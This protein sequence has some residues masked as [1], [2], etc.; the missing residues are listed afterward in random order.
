MRHSFLLLIYFFIFSINAQDSI[1]IYFDINSCVLDKNA[2]SSLKNIE[3]Y[4]G[5]IIGVYGFTDTIGSIDF[6][7]KLALKRINSICNY[8]KMSNPISEKEASIGEL[9]QFAP[10]DKDNRKVIIR[11]GN[12]NELLKEKLKNAKQGDKILLKTLN[13]EV[14]LDVL[15]PESL[16]ILTELFSQMSNNKKLKIEIQGNI[17]CAIHDSS[18]LSTDRAMRV[19]EFLSSKGIS[20]D[21]MTY[22]GFGVTNPIYKIP[23]LNERER[24]ANRRVEIKIISN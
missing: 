4:Q 2:L 23:E 9:F 16:P 21:R 1:V 5:S 13:F 18:N 14:N 6:N 15:L 20:T 17:C 22:I 8:L 3:T 7:Q 24:I 19:Y 12:E 11:L 10:L